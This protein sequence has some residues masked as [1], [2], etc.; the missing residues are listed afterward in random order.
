MLTCL[1]ACSVV[2]SAHADGS[3]GNITV[4]TKKA[5]GTLDAIDQYALVINQDSRFEAAANYVTDALDDHL[6]EL[7]RFGFIERCLKGDKIVEWAICQP[8]ID[9]FNPAKALAEIKAD[10][11]HPDWHRSALRAE[12][13]AVKPKL[14]E[15]AA[16]VKEAMDKVYEGSCGKWVEY[17]Y[18][19]DPKPPIDT[20]SR[21][22][23]ALKPGMIVTMVNQ[24]ILVGA[25][26]LTATAPSVVF[27]VAVK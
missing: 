7:G 15:H 9:A 22:A 13:E 18:T 8:D 17:T 12:L 1:L 26:S 20:P 14:K 10:T 6:T 11:K 25:A 4:D 19:V 24:S 23:A 21:Y 3:A 16:N 5:W 2:T 27:G